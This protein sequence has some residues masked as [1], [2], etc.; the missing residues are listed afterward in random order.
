MSPVPPMREETVLLKDRETSEVL[1]QAPI[2]RVNRDIQSLVSQLER[3]GLVSRSRG[4]PA[5]T[6]PGNPS[7]ASLQS[8]KA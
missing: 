5:K 3:S 2:S 4:H 1:F 6:M 7:S 8:G